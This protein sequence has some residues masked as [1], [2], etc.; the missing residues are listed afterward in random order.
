MRDVQDSGR[1]LVGN[2]PAFWQEIQRI[3]RASDVSVF[4]PSLE[5]GPYQLQ[6]RRVV[7]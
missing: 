7:T 3:P 6:E 5:L 1:G 2:V 4:Q